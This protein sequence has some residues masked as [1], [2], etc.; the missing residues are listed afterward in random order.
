[1]MVR[2]LRRAVLLGAAL[3][4]GLSAAS[5]GLALDPA[6][7]PSGVAFDAPPAAA[8]QAPAEGPAEAPA[9][10]LDAPAPPDGANVPAAPPPASAGTPRSWLATG[11]ANPLEAATR[12]ESSS[13]TGLTLGAVLLVL[14]LGAAALVMRHKRQKLAPLGPDESRLTVLSTSRVGPKAYAVTAHVNGRALLLG[15][16]DHT[17]TNLGWLDIREPAAGEAPAEAALADDDD[18]LPDDYPGSALRAAS[19]VPPTFASASSLKR[20]QDVLRGAEQARGELPLRPSYPPPASDAASLL[21]A[22][23]SDIVGGAPLQAA[24]LSL[25]RKR[26]SRDSIAPSQPQTSRAG[27][28]ARAG[29]ASLE[30]QAAGLRALRNGG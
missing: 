28:G 10:A 12:E 4:G 1:M 14:A 16:T 26:R 21:A 25:R 18:E 23:T 24:P 8:V 30:G 15:V 3:A 22:Q 9:G 17:V 13:G 6:G 7:A 29:G 27:D 11:S 2:R 20:F 19:R 5:R